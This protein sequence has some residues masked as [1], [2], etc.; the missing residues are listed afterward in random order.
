MLNESV[1]DEMKNSWHNVRGATE[2]ELKH[3]E[4]EALRRYGD[5]INLSR[6]RAYSHPPLSMEM[7]AA[8]FAPFAALDGYGS[9]IQET[10]RRTKRKPVLDEDQREELDRRLAGILTAPE[11]ERR[12][13]ITLFVPDE[14]KEG[15]KIITE[16]A[17]ISR[18]DPVSR[19]LVLAN[20][21]RIPIKDILEL[22][23]PEADSPS[24]SQE[25]PGEAPQSFPRS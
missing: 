25:K 22:T 1:D 24:A 9:A 16:E 14:R 4:V 13:R 7:R 23:A 2:D 15:G 18:A 3:G 12:V 17:V 20:R 10:G 11:R 6:P 5:I 8:Q 19:E 21:Q